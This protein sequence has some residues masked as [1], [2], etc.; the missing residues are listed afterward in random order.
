[1]DERVTQHY[2]DGGDLADRIAERLTEAGVDLDSLTPG[3]LASVD[4]FHIR[5]RAATLGL[6]AAMRLTADS[7]V[8]DI[9]SGLGGSA[10][11]IAETYGC[12]VTGVDLTEAF[13]NAANVMS[14][15]V[16]LSDSVTFRQADAT[17]LPFD[18]D[19][20][21]AAMTLHVAMNIEAKDRLFAEAK[22]VVKPGGIFA[23]FDVVQGEGG[24]VLYPVPWARDTGIGHLATP[25]E[26][27]A[28]LR[29]AGLRVLQVEDST[30]DSQHWFE[31]V[32]ARM[33]DHAPPPAA[34]RVVLGR[35]FPEMARNMLSNLT[36]RRIRSISYICAC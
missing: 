16:E 25:A 10:R 7:H 8:L 31:R 21:D 13:C 24:P 29:G 5:G 14:E 18:D 33:A 11:A 1:M 35:D 27:T 23:T 34:L 32:V 15:W 17:D 2:A 6:A 30:H 26:M 36:Q 4:Q 9:G 12:R 22:R 19:S 28:L 20:F 3:E